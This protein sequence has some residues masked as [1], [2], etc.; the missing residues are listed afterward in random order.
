MTLDYV[1]FGIEHIWVID[2]YQ[3]RAFR[4]DARGFHEPEEGSVILT[5]PG[6]PIAVSLAE[7]WRELGP[8]V[9]D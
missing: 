7:V 4:A 5:V 2:P 6:T 8:P 1:Q 9:E 3:S